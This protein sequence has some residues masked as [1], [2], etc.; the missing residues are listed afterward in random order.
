MN[1]I[2]GFLA[3][4]IFLALLADCTPEAKLDASRAPAQLDE[5]DL[6]GECAV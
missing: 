6:P 1:A 5:L 3:L 2:S 4:A